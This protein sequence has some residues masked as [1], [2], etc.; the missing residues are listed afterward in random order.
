MIEVLKKYKWYALT[1]MAGVILIIMHFV[2][3]TEIP[4]GLNV[5]EVSAAYDAY[6]IAHYGVDRHLKSYPLYFTNYGD[7]QN[8]LYIYITAL[9]FKVFGASKVTIRVSMAVFALV[10]GYFGYAYMANMWK[11]R[12]G[13]VLWLCLYGILPVFTMA[14]RFG[15]E[16][17]LML[18]LSMV[19]IFFMAKA[20]DTE[21][22]KYYLSAGIVLGITLYTYALTYIVI[23]IFLVLM[24][25]YGFLLKKINLKRIVILGIPLMLLAIPLILVQ[26]VNYF[27]LPEMMI[28]PFT[29]TKLQGYRLEEVTGASPIQNIKDILFHTFL[30]DDL[31]YNTFPTYGTMFYVSIPFVCLG[32]GRAVADVIRSVREKKFSYSAPM[33]FWYIAEWMMGLLLTGNSTPNTTRMNG[34]FMPMLYFLVLGLY[35]VYDWIRLDKGKQIYAGVMGLMYA[36]LFLS[37]STF[38]FT[39]YNEKAFPLK[40]LFHEDYED[41]GDFLVENADATWIHRGVC[42]PWN[43]AYYLWEFKVNPYEFNMPENGVKYFGKDVV[44]SYPAEI[45]IEKNYVVY[46]SDK[47][48]L[49]QLTNMGYMELRVSDKFSFLVSPLDAYVQ[50]VN[51][52]NVQISLDKICIEENQLHFLG[53]CVDGQKLAAY[54]QIYV[55]VADAEYPALQSQRADVATH[56]QSDACLNSGFSVNLPLA[57]LATAQTIEFV[58]VGEDGAEETMMS[59]YRK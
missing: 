23:P 30:Y 8:A 13:K 46:E 1:V 51:S 27:D 3:M 31:P 40:W 22:W 21:N 18:P 35:Q 34:I 58:G 6:N 28:G 37:F 50:E 20:L 42:Y 12:Q 52:D 38:Y 57:T 59:F 54:S 9:L 10:A 45:Q 32:C 16:S 47:A 14:Q 11:N 19:A 4:Y 25:V 7:G 41:V 56:L 55:R 53:W 17:H 49:E 44:N 33:L 15:L 26:A 39:D 48:S 29:I 2:R 24:L 43:Y 5:D 36:V